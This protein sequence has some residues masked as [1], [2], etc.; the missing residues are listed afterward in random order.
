[1]DCRAL[2]LS[3]AVLGAG[4]L[5]SSTACTAPD[6]GAITFAERPGQAGPPQGST[7][8]DT[9][10]TDDDGGSSGST[11]ADPI[12]GTA[13]FAYV[14]PGLVAN[15]ANAAHG[16]TVE[17]KDCS[18]AGCHINDGTSAKPWLIGGT[19]YTAA[20]DGQTVAKGEVRVIGPDNTE[21]AHAYTDANGNFW[22]GA[23]GGAKIPAGSKV[24]ARSETGKSM[25][26]ALALGPD[27]SGCTASRANC[28][29]TSQGKVYTQ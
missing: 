3:C 23:A 11:T 16:G 15:N 9:T 12:F 18:A 29:G 26:M 13:A 4:V 19:L 24:G 6:P 21:V 25:F 27:D 2:L 17:G 8:G 5:A 28:H 1:M 22:F 20:T 10:P 7:S 14:D